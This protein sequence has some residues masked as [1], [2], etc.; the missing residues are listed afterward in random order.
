MDSQQM[1]DLK[2]S[3]IFATMTA[4][5]KQA[6][7]EML[8]QTEQL[9]RKQAIIDRRPTATKS[10]VQYVDDLLAVE[11][12]PLKTRLKLLAAMVRV[13]YP[14]A[15]DQSIDYVEEISKFPKDQVL[16]IVPAVLKDKNLNWSLRDKEG[17][18]AD[19]LATLEPHQEPEESLIDLPLDSVTLPVTSD[20]VD[21]LETSEPVIEKIEESQ[22]KVTSKKK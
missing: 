18:L 5:Q 22:E 3:P 2:N 6:V 13:I 15:I 19:L 17:Q 7:I 12:E 1:I 9:A 21:N 20:K 10:V 11:G 8:A 4:E 14:Q 16:K